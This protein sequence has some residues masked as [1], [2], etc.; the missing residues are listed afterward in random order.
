MDQG[1]ND[2]WPS[3]VAITLW[4]IGYLKF[5]KLDPHFTNICLLSPQNEEWVIYLV[6]VSS[7]VV[8]LKTAEPKE[9]WPKKESLC[10]ETISI[11]ACIRRMKN[12]FLS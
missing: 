10:F 7:E 8:T 11:W 5:S 1:N 3:I 2:M 6:S 12:S 4:K 9:V